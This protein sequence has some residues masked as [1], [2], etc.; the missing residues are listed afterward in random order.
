M[1]KIFKYLNSN[2]TKLYLIFAN[3]ILVIFAIWFSN[4]GLLPFH[5]LSDFLVFAVLGL[6]LAIYRPGWVF[7]LFV[8]SLVLEN[9]NLAPQSL[10][11]AMRP[12]QFFGAIIIIALIIRTATKRLP[13][14]VKEFFPKF[15]WFDI[16]PII[17]AAGGF[18]SSLANGAG[19]KQAIVAL[20]FV[21]LYFLARIYVQNTEDLKRVLPFFLSS[22]VVVV[23]YGILQNILFISGKNSFE[24]MPGRPNGTFSEPDWF[25]IYLTFF[26]AIIFSL[27]FYYN[28]K[29]NGSN[30]SSQISNFEF[31]ISNQIQI[32]ND[33]IK[34]YIIHT[35][36][37]ILLML[38][39]VCLIITVSRSAWLGAVFV[40]IG[41]LKI[42]LTNGSFRFSNWDW[43]KLLCSLGGMAAVIILSI[44]S[45]YVFGLSRFQIGNR[46]AST[47]G[48]QKITIAC[49][50]GMDNAVPEKINNI[51]ELAQ[52]NCRHI[53]LEDIEKEK[54]AGNV[55]QE[56]YR[57]DPNVNIRADIY[58][59]SWEQ[60]KQHPV[61]GI[62]WGTISQIL[63]TDERGTGLNA[64]NIFLETWLGS[65]IAGL[66]AFLC[67]LM[68]IFFKSLKDMFSDNLEKKVIGSFVIL[69]LFAFIVPNLFNSGIFLGI[70][71]VFLGIAVN[72][73]TT[74]GR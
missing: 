72:M 28:R 35:T 55:V 20:S 2:L 58:Q 53:N 59:K 16:L 38:I 40:T 44:G 63:G 19:F 22:A 60:I 9:V 66:L 74:K 64:S 30:L 51:A 8:G 31:L 56:V 29:P 6:L 73:E 14:P 54:T 34:R 18:L 12:Y 25:G 26:V 61:F 71:W 23:L 62:G 68:Y 57:P 48:L 21:V 15:K 3:I 46:A 47:G 1:E 69:G 11:L 37:Y 65:G 39:F 24:V 5:N 32:S 4:V 70:L 50:G 27:I 42:M 10:G 41:F 49:Q 52:Y 7:V 33:K 67:I 17:F 45:V 13:L 36:L 43:K